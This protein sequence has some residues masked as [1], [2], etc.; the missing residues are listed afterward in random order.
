MRATWRLWYRPC[1]NVLLQPLQNLAW[2]VSL[3]SRT[4]GRGTDL[5]A[6]GDHDEPGERQSAGAAAAAGRE[7]GYAGRERGRGSHE[8]PDVGH[9]S[10]YRHCGPRDCPRVRRPQHGRIL[11]PAHCCAPST[12]PPTA[13][14]VSPAWRA[15]GR[16]TALA[17]A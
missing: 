13:T 15:P 16:Q 11:R 1:I 7:R 2:A 12:T 17:Y 14:G 6:K 5:T 8:E 3:Q 4:Q 9:R 10:G